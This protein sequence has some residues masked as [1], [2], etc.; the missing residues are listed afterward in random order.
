MVRMAAAAADLD[1][2]RMLI[3]ARPATPGV[4]R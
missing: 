4:E 2:E 1:V 3:V